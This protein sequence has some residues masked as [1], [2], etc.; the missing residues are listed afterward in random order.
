MAPPWPRPPPAAARA[1]PLV[2]TQ[3]PR[4]V[5]GPGSHPEPGRPCFPHPAPPVT[6]TT[7]PETPFVLAPAC[8]CR[9]AVLASSAHAPRL[10]RLG[11]PRSPRWFFLDPLPPH[12]SSSP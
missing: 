4:R 7:P 12:S 3:P 6:P 5:H 11:C 2:A 1:R 8:P 10:G 9:A